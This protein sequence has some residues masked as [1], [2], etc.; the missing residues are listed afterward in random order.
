[1]D[2][3]QHLVVTRDDLAEIETLTKDLGS[4]PSVEDIESVVRMRDSLVARMKQSERRLAE[5]DA[6]WN[7]RVDKDP[8]L[9][10]LFEESRALL[11]SVADID[12]RLAVLIELRM[13]AV[14]QQLSALY[15]SSRAAYSYTTHSIL[16]TARS[17]V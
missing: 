2:I 6:L 12:S 16:R 11:S 10:N 5:H 13:A 7:K 14:K 17:A 9:K 4:E 1:M 8:F 15:H 3:R